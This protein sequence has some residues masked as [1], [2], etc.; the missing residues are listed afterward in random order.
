MTRTAIVIPAYNAA[1]TIGATLES[2]QRCRKIRAVDGIFVCDDASTDSTVD[3]AVQYW[4]GK[5]PLTVLRNERN[6]GERA[7][8]NRLLRQLGNEYQWAYI[9]HADDLLKENWLELYFNRIQNAGARVA[10]ICSSYDCWYPESNT[11]VPGEDDF[12]RDDE[13]IRGSRES[14]IGTLGRGCWWH[15]SGCAIQMKHFFD[16]GEFRTDLPYFGDYDWLLR[17]LKSG[18]DVQYIP[19]TT[20]LY[21]MHAGSV[22]GTSLKSGRD[23][24]ERLDIF[25]Q[26]FSEGYLSPY[27]WRMARIRVVYWALRRTFKQAAHNEL[28][29]TRQ[30]LSVCRDAVKGTILQ[31][32]RGLPPC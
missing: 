17:C 3:C 9:L 20:M 26:Y 30:L 18:H 21:R 10:S 23:L 27:E 8:V 11:V 13:I 29:A 16:I 2:V 31:R 6:I 25:G 4:N 15:I 32:P 22:S 24:K 14:V 1:S 5:I 28:N 12:S 7:T 19:R